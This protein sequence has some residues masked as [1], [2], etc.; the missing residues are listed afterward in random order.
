VAYTDLSAIKFTQYYYV[1]SAVSA[2]GESPDSSPEATATPTGTYAPTAYEPFNYG[3]LA[4]NDASTA[5]GFTGNWTIGGSVSI[6]GN[7]SYP[8]LPTANSSFQQ[9]PG[10]QRDTV[11]LATPLSGG[12][13]FVSFLYNQAGDNG[14]NVNGLFLPGSGSTSLF[15]GLTA[16][17]SGTAGSFG[18][19]SVVTANGS[20]TGLSSLLGQ[21]NGGLNYNQTNFIVVGIEFNTSGNNDTVSL[22]INPP[23]GVTALPAANLTVSSYDVGSIT[24]VGFNFQGGG[25]VEQYDEIRVGDTYGDVSG[26]AVSSVNTTPTN[27]VSVVS[28]SQ[29]TLSWPADHTG[30]KLQSQTNNLN[31]GISGTWFDVAGSTSTNE[32]TF[33]IDPANP[34]VFY[35]MTYP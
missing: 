13:K 12:T 23:A 26:Y 25:A 21:L 29:L 11:S 24:G 2:Y 7:L 5:S 8:A 19:A 6:I 16:P 28:G 35:R 18:L 22:W 9:L 31:T 15:V 30:W 1:V 4:N 20:A 27:I 10:G 3:S 14:G 32:M 34:T 33:T 17:F